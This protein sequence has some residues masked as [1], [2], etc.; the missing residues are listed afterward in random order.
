MKQH[1]YR[2]KQYKKNYEKLEPICGSQTSH[3]EWSRAITDEKVFEELYKSSTNIA[4]IRCH[5]IIKNKIQ[6]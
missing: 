6:S 1:L 4:C 5:E 3:S 2:W